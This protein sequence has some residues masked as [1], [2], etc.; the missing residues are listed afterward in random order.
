M[1]LKGNLLIIRK[2][3]EVVN[4][5]KSWIIGTAITRQR[6]TICWYAFRWSVVDLIASPM[7]ATLEGVIEANPVSDLMGQNLAVGHV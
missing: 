5:V 7:A 3:H 2:I 4:R 6:A 1:M